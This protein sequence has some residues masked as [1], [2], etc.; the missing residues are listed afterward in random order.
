MRDSNGK[1]TLVNPPTLLINERT[2]N[3]D[4]IKIVCGGVH[5]KY[6]LTAKTESGAV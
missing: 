6:L 2:R 5:K 1:S 4:Q 3:Y